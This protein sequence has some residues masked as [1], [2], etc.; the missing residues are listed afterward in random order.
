MVH[1]YFLIYYLTLIL[2]FIFL[3]N[4]TLTNTTKA[5]ENKYTKCNIGILVVCKNVDKIG[6]SITITC[7]SIEQKN[8]K[9]INLFVLI[10][11]L[12]V[13]DFSL[14]QLKT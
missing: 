2:Y 1:C 8:A 9:A 14:R 11:I 13:L 3:Y 7:K 4:S 12:K 6:T 5:I 10:D